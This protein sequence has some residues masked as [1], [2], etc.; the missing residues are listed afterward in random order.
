MADKNEWR[1]DCLCQA[2]GTTFAPAAVGFFAAD[3]AGFEPGKHY[4][5]AEAKFLCLREP[6]CS[7]VTCAGTGPRPGHY[8]AADGT[9]PVVCAEPA[10]C[11]TLRQHADPL[12][13]SRTGEATHVKIAETAQ[14][15]T[16]DDAKDDYDYYDYDDYCDDYPL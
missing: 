13:L 5:L 2:P 3:Y 4:R 6:N 1:F 14:G 8:P 7:A 15:S 16:A 12:L 10:E 9:L 11:C